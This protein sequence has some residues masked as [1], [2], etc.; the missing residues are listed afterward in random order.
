MTVKTVNE[1]G[2]FQKQ[3]QIDQFHRS[4]RAEFK[5]MHFNVALSVCFST[6]AKKG[7]LCILGKK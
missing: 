2:L 7:R 5:N 3:K 6:V 4:Q 1:L